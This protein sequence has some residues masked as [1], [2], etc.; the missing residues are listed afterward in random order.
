MLGPP[1]N[2][3]DGVVERP[4]RCSEAGERLIDHIEIHKWP[5]PTT[6][7]VYAKDDRRLVFLT[8]EIDVQRSEGLGR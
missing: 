4:T 3:E 1:N 2:V 6:S 8:F 5:C 7:P